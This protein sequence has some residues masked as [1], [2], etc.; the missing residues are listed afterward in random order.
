MSLFLWTIKSEGLYTS[1][2][3]ED[4]NDRSTHAEDDT[5]LVCNE[6]AESLDSPT[7]IL[8]QVQ[9]LPWSTFSSPVGR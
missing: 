6:L 3:K 7:D 9:E 4:T 8:E 1:A 5:R 2:D